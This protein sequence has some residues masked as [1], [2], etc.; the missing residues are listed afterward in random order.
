MDLCELLS[1]E[2]PILLDGAMATQLASFG[3][4]MGGQK[5]VTHPETVLTIRRLGA[6]HLR[7][8][9]HLN[10]RVLSQGLQIW[11]Y[12]WG[13]TI[14]DPGLRQTFTSQTR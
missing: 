2:T 4:E 12:V 1:G 11:L 13:V 9:N 3:L 6:D 7:I 14:D 5:N 8:G 10:I